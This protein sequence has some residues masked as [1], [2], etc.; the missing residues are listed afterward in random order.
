MPHI[1]PRQH[2]HELI[3]RMDSD[4]V[5]AVVNLLEVMLAPHA[6]TLA[7]IPYEGE[8]ISEEENR[9]VVDLKSGFRRTKV[10]RTKKCLPSLA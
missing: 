9:E 7:H 3:D 8:T 1:E 10:F 2:A 4:Q 6:R 5:S